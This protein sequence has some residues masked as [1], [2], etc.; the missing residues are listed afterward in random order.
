MHYKQAVLLEYLKAVPCPSDDIERLLAKSLIQAGQLYQLRIFIESRVIRESAQLANCLLNSAKSPQE[1]VFRLGLDIL[2]KL[3]CFQE[4]T[5]ILLEKL[6][7][8][9]NCQPEKCCK[10]EI[11]AL[12]IPRHQLSQKLLLR[13]GL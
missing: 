11:L 9:L 4:I 8:F 10:E 12:H 7:Q 13:L 5:Q 3:G 1:P 6:V 2:K